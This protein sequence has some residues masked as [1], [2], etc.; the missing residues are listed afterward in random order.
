MG[1]FEF[2]LAETLEPIPASSKQIVGAYCRDVVL[3]I[4]CTDVARLMRE[5]TQLLRGSSWANEYARGNNLSMPKFSPLP[6]SPVVTDLANL[7]SI[8]GLQDSHDRLRSG[9]PRG[10]NRD[11]FF[12]ERLELL[13]RS[14]QRI[15][16]IDPYA[17]SAGGARTTKW[18]VDRC[19]GISIGFAPK[20]FAIVTEVVE[21]PLAGATIIQLDGFHD[22]YLLFDDTFAIGLG[23]GLSTFRG[24]RAYRSQC[25][26]Q[27]YSWANRA[28][29]QTIARLSGYLG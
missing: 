17:L 13:A 10:T 18:F 9:I 11:T 3:P 28:D 20:A 26:F 16:V 22:R 27:F 1:L 23:S 24:Q 15:A 2:A 19:R 5:L 25:S 14:S 8:G 29:R 21:S 6:P 7:S 12:T 4:A